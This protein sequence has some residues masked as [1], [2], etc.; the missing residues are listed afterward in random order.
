MA[1]KPPAGKPASKQRAKP[2][3][4]S[5]KR[6]VAALEHDAGAAAIIPALGGPT[7][8][9]DRAD[10]VAAGRELRKAVPRSAHGEW[11]PAPDRPDPVAVLVEQGESR[12]PELLPIRY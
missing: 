6:G 11:Q 10:R 12:V 9:V 4:K 1:P 2:A 5:R 3:L 7:G 8:R